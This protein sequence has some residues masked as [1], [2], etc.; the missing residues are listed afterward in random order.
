MDYITDLNTDSPHPF[1]VTRLIK[2][3]QVQIT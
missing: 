3:K 1:Y 2:D